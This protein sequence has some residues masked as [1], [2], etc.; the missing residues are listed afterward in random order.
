AED[1]DVL[2]GALAD[3][4]GVYYNATGGVECFSPAAGAN[5][6]SSVDGDNWNWQ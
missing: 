6:E 3:A 4:I 1:D 2:L 5:N